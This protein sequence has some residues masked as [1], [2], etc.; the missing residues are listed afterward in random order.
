MVSP[1]RLSW[2]HRNSAPA[3]TGVYLCSQR[4]HTDAQ[5]WVPPLAASAPPGKCTHLVLQASPARQ[6]LNWNTALLLNSELNLGTSLGFQFNSISEVDGLRRA[7][8][9]LWS[10]SH[11]SYSMKV[12]LL[13]KLFHKWSKPWFRWALLTAAVLPSRVIR[14]PVIHPCDKYFSDSILILQPLWY[15]EET[16]PQKAFTQDKKGI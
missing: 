3:V 7:C 12:I 16:H 2:E 10:P 6:I 1:K 4:R 9:K 15:T 11:G 5:P 8:T 14:K 13:T